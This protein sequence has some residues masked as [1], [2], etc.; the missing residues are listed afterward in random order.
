MRAVFT[1]ALH[2]LRILLRDKTGFIWMLVVPCVYILVFGSAFKNRQDPA[3]AKAYLA[4]YNQDQGFLSERLLAG[5]QSE[6]ISIDTLETYPQEPLTR[7]LVIPDSFTT[8]LLNAKKVEL[9]FEKK[10]GTNIEAEATAEMAIRKSYFRLLADMS[11][12]KVNETNLTTSELAALDSIP[13]KISVNSS[14]AGKHV[15]V[16]AG[17]DHQVP[18]NIVMFTLLTLFLYAGNSM[19]DEKK[20]GALRRIKIAPLNFVHLFVGKLLNVLLVGLIQIGL[21]LIIGHFV[22]G[23]YYGN[24]A[25][26]LLL[27]SVLFAGCVGTMGLCLGF[28]FDNEE[29]LIGTAIISSLVMA[30]VSGCWWP[31]EVS[32]KWMQ[33]FSMLLPSGLAIKSFHQLISYGNGF[34]YI[35][36]Y[37]VGLLC[38]AILFSILLARLLKKSDSY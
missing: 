36:K 13:A 34:L 19:L 18:A 11:E 4:V 25:I 21:L 38:M 27:L 31:M 8:N 20:S 12:I 15:I 33:N 7:M 37:L 6:A 32:P 2:A 26:S 22:F 17:F 10:S 23:V 14:Y 5:I 9:F 29:R 3:K 24:S 30:A 1:I 28:I 16:P 35:W